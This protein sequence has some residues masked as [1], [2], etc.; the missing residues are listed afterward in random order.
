MMSSRVLTSTVCKYMYE[1][2]CVWPTHTEADISVQLQYHV[3]HTASLSS[4]TVNE[5]S[6]LSPLCRFLLH[7]RLLSLLESYKANCLSLLLWMVIK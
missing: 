3:S 5:L 7:P 2:V 6:L 4:M 1:Y